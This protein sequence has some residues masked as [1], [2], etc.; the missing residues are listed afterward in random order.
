M[1][2]ILEGEITIQKSK[3]LYNKKLR[4]RESLCL[5]LFLNCRLRK[6]SF[7]NLNENVP[8]NRTLIEH[9]VEMHC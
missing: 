9:T 7:T 6:I 8:T 5:N 4:E 2:Y 1:K 3:I